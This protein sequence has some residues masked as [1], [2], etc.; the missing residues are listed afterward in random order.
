MFFKSLPAQKG[1]Q[2]KERSSFK[3]TIDE[4]VDE[5]EEKNRTR[6]VLITK[7]EEI[8]EQMGEEW[9]NAKT[10]TSNKFHQKHDEKKDN[11]PVE[12]QVPA[13]YHEFLDIF[14]EVKAN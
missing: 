7:G 2:R 14:D 6:N 1:L 9:M 3:P 13:E 4:I 8:L 5:E 10:T 11:L 12:E